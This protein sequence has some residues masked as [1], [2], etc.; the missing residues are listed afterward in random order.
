M[1]RNKHDR[2]A[3]WCRG[4]EEAGKCPLVIVDMLQ[5]VKGTYDVECA[6]R[7]LEHVEFDQLDVR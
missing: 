5:H 6:R 2:A 1:L 3:P 4:G 7:R